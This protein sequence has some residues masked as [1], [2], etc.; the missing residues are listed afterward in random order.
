MDNSVLT[1]STM[2]ANLVLVVS[3][4]STEP[5]SWVEYL[6]SDGAGSLLDVLPPSCN[7]R[8]DVALQPVVNL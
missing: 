3:N 1:R 5:E 2:P 8:V 4:Y 7:S 6:N